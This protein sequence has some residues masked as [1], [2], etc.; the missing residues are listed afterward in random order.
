MCKCSYCGKFCKND[1]SLRN[2][3][4]LCRFNPNRQI[5]KSNFVEWNKKRKKYGIKGENQYTKAKRL[6]INKPIISDETRYKMGNSWRG[7]KHTE[8]EKIAISNGMK[9]AVKENPES[10]SSININ[11]RVGVY[12]YKGVKLNGTWEVIFAEYLDRN[13][14]RW[15]RPTIGFEYI[16]NNDKHTYYPDF[17]LPDIDVYVEIKGYERER[18]KFKWKSVSNLIIIKGNEIRQIE[19]NTF[20]IMNKIH[21]MLV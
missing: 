15:E 9:K 14:I 6:G 11:G 13:N 1:N 12:Y 19:N 3:E 18:D 2:H 7:K 20:D 10:Y 16:W 8:Q 21:Q 17:Y 4:R 5:L